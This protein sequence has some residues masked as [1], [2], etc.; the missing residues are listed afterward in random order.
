MYCYLTHVVDTN[1]Y[2]ITLDSVS[3]VQDFIDS[4]L[5]YMHGLL[6]DHEI[7]FATKLVLGITLISKEPY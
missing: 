3:M 7:K 4:F 6:P 2:S 5:K 1:E